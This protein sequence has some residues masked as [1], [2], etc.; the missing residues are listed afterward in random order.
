[1]QT[2]PQPNGRH[3]TAGTNGTPATVT[4]AD[5]QETKTALESALVQVEGIKTSF[6]E[7]ING[8][9]K[10]GDHI[11]QAMR[12]QKSGEKEIQGIRQTLRTLQSVRI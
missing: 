4:T 3:H 6:R 10:V 7:A 1:M 5:K 8:L 2:H 11:R 9:T 12:E